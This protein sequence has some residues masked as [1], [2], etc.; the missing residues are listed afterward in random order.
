MPVAAIVS[1]VSIGQV[2]GHSTNIGA[3][4][5]S[6]DFRPLGE[7]DK[8]IESSYDELIDV[9]RKTVADNEGSAI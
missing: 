3:P 2:K 1:I 8:A 4:L 5:P 6:M 9:K 7:I